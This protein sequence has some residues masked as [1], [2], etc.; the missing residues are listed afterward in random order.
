MEGFVVTS[1]A[2]LVEVDEFNPAGLGGVDRAGEGVTACGG[3][4]RGRGEE[5]EGG[6]GGGR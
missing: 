1:P 5:L 6:T 4:E 2:G 3:R